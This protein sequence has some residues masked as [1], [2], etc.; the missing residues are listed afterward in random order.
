MEDRPFFKIKNMTGDFSPPVFT[1]TGESNKS[2]S[3]FIIKYITDVS[4]DTVSVSTSSDLNVYSSF[5]YRKIF[6][7]MF[8]GLRTVSKRVITAKIT[9]KRINKSV[10][11]SILHD[12]INVINITVTNEFAFIK[13][14]F[15]KELNSDKN[16]MSTKGFSWRCSFLSLINR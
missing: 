14:I 13:Y 2:P 6:N 1:K 5:I 4:F 10:L 9:V 15:I 16:I 8:A 12:L 7:N 3:I 11:K